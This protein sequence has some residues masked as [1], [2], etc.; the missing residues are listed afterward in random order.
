M[1]TSKE[2]ATH[3]YTKCGVCLREIKRCM[4]RFHVFALQCLASIVHFTIDGDICT[5][6]YTEGARQ[7]VDVWKSVY[8]YMS[9]LMI[10]SC[11]NSV[12]I[13]MMYCLSAQMIFIVLLFHINAK[14]HLREHINN[15]PI[16]RRVIIHIS[17]FS[18]KPCH[19]TYS[20]QQRD[21]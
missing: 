18:N 11:E 15:L 10:M 4:K 9:W 8:D 16:P 12:C 7:G 6:T 2:S 5:K 13:V 19:T 21:S 20:V 1:V 3:F 14:T 17:C